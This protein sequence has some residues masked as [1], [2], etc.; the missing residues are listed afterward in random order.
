MSW[1]HD[2]ETILISGNY[3]HILSSPPTATRGTAYW[4]TRS[5]QFEKSSV[6]PYLTGIV[7]SVVDHNSTNYFIGDINSAQRY[8]ADDLSF[9]TS[10]RSDTLSFFNSF[11]PQGD[12]RNIHINTA[13]IN[14]TSNSNEVIVLGGQ[15]LLEDNTRNIAIYDGSSNTW[16]GIQ[17]TSD[18]TGEVNTLLAVNGDLLF[19]GGNSTIT[20]L[21]V[22]SL[23]NKTLIQTPNVQPIDSLSGTSVDAIVFI[24]QENVVIV[25]GTFSSI[26]MVSCSS[27]CSLDIE[28]HQ[29]SALGSGFEG[30][31]LDF[32]YI[33]ET[34]VVA[35]NITLNKSPVSVA[36]YNF[37]SNTWSSLGDKN[38]LPGPSQALSYDN[39]TQSI[40][41]SGMSGSTAY[42]RK[43]NGKQFIELDQKLGEVSVITS[44]AT[45]PLVNH[46]SSDPTTKKNILLATGSINLGAYNVSS[47]F[48]D[49]NEEEW[50]PYLLT[51]NTNEHSNSLSLKGLFY[52]DEP[53]L[54]PTKAK[55]PPE[56][57]T[58]SKEPLPV[59]LVILVSI[60][61]SLSIIFLLVALAML[62]A[63]LKR[64][65]NRSISPKNKPNTYYSGPP[66]SPEAILAML[67]VK[68][69]NDEKYATKN[70]T[71]PGK[72][73][74]QTIYNM[75]NSADQVDRSISSFMIPVAAVSGATRQ[76]PSPPTRTYR[77]PHNYRTLL[78]PFSRK[79]A[80][81]NNL[82]ATEPKR[83]T[84]KRSSTLPA[85]V[86]TTQ[87]DSEL[88]S[89]YNS[90][91]TNR[92]ISESPTS[93]DTL[94]S[95]Y[96]NF[97]I[98]V[99]VKEGNSRSIITTTDM[100]RD[101]DLVHSPFTPN[102]TSPMS[103]FS[104]Q[105]ESL[106]WT[107][108][109]TGNMSHAASLR[110][111]MASRR[112]SNTNK[113]YSPLNRSTREA[114]ERLPP[115]N[116][117]QSQHAPIRG[118][119]LE[120]SYGHANPSDGFWNDP[121]IVKFTSQPQNTSLSSLAWPQI[122][123]YGQD[124]TLDGADALEQNNHLKNDSQD[125]LMKISTKMF[126]LS[127]TGSVMPIEVRR[128]PDSS[129]RWKTA[130]MGSPIETAYAPEDILL[131][132]SSVAVT[133][134]TGSFIRR[135]SDLTMDPTPSRTRNDPATRESPKKP[136]GRAAS[137]RMVEDYMSKKRN[138][139]RA[140]LKS[141][142]RAIMQSAIVNNATRLIATEEYPHL[143]YAKFD[144]VAREEGELGFEKGDP[145]IVVDSSDDIWWTGYKTNSKFESEICFAITKT[146]FY[147]NR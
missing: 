21:V 1:L 102:S 97:E 9:V 109:P 93:F 7:Y 87:R 96:R 127:D 19:A 129:V 53:Y 147:R 54:A 40:Y 106:K 138:N 107:P 122:N 90:E 36:E 55:K 85:A 76:A 8:Q 143:Y 10:T 43:W 94:P 135:Q 66:A 30:S 125:E 35:G 17:G 32:Q 63:Y 133:S 75:T 126:R 121:D 72:E 132:P 6:F 31:V 118:P 82:T 130:Q 14:K 115:S 57:S 34:L 103:G 41:I 98:G 108:K 68:S 46:N 83:K 71:K 38:D 62:I 131:E 86:N 59:P 113:P 111:N 39:I 91:Y 112:Q 141:D 58:A 80:S 100:V 110:E 22:F 65:R 144:F 56:N 136:V 69:P 123:E 116:I 142:F 25:G 11:M 18:W 44:L 81:F 28:S 2:K 105:S 45:L 101:E 70:H 47:A 78:G 140:Q 49:E 124:Y 12:Q 145:I 3:S 42:L 37:T 117:V 134:R 95:P 67:K 77:Q 104:G 20:S 120:G 146:S 5:Q 73:A 139:P 23:K 119:A 16:E 137:K 29:W 64:K 24:P 99:A 88:S 15:F 51:S 114:L 48:Y 26:D 52:M 128:S 84:K 4:D 60:A 27:L 50:I 13:Y 61:I 33:N 89:F 79:S 92:K 74:T